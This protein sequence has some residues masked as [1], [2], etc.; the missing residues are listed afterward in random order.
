MDSERE[1]GDVLD[2]MRPVTRRKFLKWA[3]A[4]GVS[5]AVP[6]AELIRN[7]ALVMAGPSPR[8]GGTVRV[9]GHHEISSL[10]PDDAGPTVHWVIVT[11][12]HNAL[13]EVN[14][15]YV[16]DRVLAE[17]FEAARDGSS[18]RFWLRRGVRFHD[19][20]E[21]TADDVKY[22]Y[23]WYMNPANNAI[24]AL[25]FHGVDRIE[26]PDKYTVVVRMREP[27]AAFLRRGATTFIVPA[28]YHGRI[29]ERAYKTAPMGTGAFRL[30]EWRAAEF[31]TVEAFDQHFRG[32]PNIDVFRQ[33]IVPEASVRAVAMRTG[34]ADSFV[35][36]LL[37]EDNLALEADTTRFR[38]YRTIS[39]AVNHFPINN[40]H[41]L[42]SDKRVRQALMHAIDRDRLIGDVFRGTAVLART[43]LAPAL[44]Q[45][46]NANVRHYD[47]SPDRARTLL[48]EA[49]WVPGPG[50]IRAREGRRASFTCTLITG[51]R[52]RRPQAEV[53]QRDLAAVGIEMHL[54]ERPTATI[55]AQLPRGEM[56]A[57]LFNWTY[58]G[59]GGEPDALATLHSGQARN[60]SR[61]NNAR[62]DELL[63]A[64][65]RE[66]DASRRRRIYND[67]QTLFAEEVPF[68]YMMYWQ[69][70]N[71]FSR[72]IQGLPRSMQAGN[73]IFRDAYR[74]WIE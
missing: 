20:R 31:T 49:G 74:W 39:L 9:T 11:Q 12:I 14:E 67:V 48:T 73:V 22:T 15:N 6:V 19:G 53:V 43:N 10:S 28:H 69:W 23:E 33:D 13:L 55:L 56:D 29:G 57:S 50:G 3:A 17:R 38:A 70:F 40:E 65:I 72:R 64:G 5:T 36:P 26:T 63:R 66:V 58:G 32:R 51:D 18:Y 62:M 42:F 7:P 71:V 52:A 8:R 47:Y 16:L 35:W 24:N 44:H 46:H 34:A 2:E 54:V 25:N 37:A 21:F 60:F 61:F 1:L 45:W 4:V 41:P 68:L 30:R 59:G 27:N